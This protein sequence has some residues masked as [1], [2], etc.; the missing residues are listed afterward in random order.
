MSDVASNVARVF[1]LAGR[2][3]RL[4]SEA[5][6]EPHLKQLDANVTE[7]IHLHG[8][9]IGIEASRALGKVLSELKVLK[10]ANF[11]D[12]FT[13]RSI[14]EIPDALTAIC[15][16]LKNLTTLEEVNF[17]DNAFGE[18]TVHPL[19]PLLMHNR[20]IRVLKLDN[21][22]LGPAAGNIVAN[23][24]LESAR[25]SKAAGTPSNLRVVI[26]GRNRLE[27]GSASAFAEAF[28]AH[29]NLTKVRMVQNGIREEGFAALV[30]GLS[31]SPSLQYLSLR[32]NLGR[33]IG[34]DDD[35]YEEGE[36]EHGWHALAAALTHWKDLRYLD[37]SDCSMHPPGF[38]LL[39]QA[40]ERGV[41][42]R[43]VALVLNGSELDNT[44][45]RN[46][47]QVVA[48][49]LPGLKYLSLLYNDDLDDDEQLLELGKVMKGRGGELLLDG[50]EDEDERDK[51]QIDIQEPLM[52][53]NGSSEVEDELV[54]AL[55]RWSIT[56]STP[57]QTA[58]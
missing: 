10:V 7:E 24:L 18:R 36:R 32:D 35:P 48:K 49:A 5:D 43:L 29:G 52:S 9:T 40:L 58:R 51:P 1:S 57:K 23:A 34:K 50:E 53:D 21:N 11:S 28:A 45:Y 12:I 39:L 22:G 47:H 42:E 33:N 54:C 37:V 55:H 44:V 8:N 41:H 30:R 3:L 27:D 46:L 19:V 31:R 56:D 17:N 38:T 15:E 14:E 6:I 20:S 2:G 4:D 25:L 16:G 26:C 13:G